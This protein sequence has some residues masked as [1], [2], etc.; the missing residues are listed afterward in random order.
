MGVRSLV[1]RSVGLAPR[2]R[3]ALIAAVTALVAASLA[4]RLLPFRRAIRFGLAEGALRE[5]NQ[6]EQL[7][8]DFTWAVEAAARHL[9]IGAKCIHKGLALQRLLRSRGVPALL[10]YGIGK[11]ESDDLA[12]HVWV[13]AG[14]RVIMGGEDIAAYRRV[15]IYP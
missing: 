1:S 6:A 11:N 2:K 15:A 12:A 10:H 5:T 3:R 9:P 13:E 14:G 4:V 7:I 8:T